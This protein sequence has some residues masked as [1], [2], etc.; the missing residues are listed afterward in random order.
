MRASSGDNDDEWDASY[1]PTYDQPRELTDRDMRWVSNGQ[2]AHQPTVPR[3]ET[4]DSIALSV[5]GEG[6]A[7]LPVTHPS[8][9]PEADSAGATA[10]TPSEDP[11]TLSPTSMK[12]A[13]R[14][15]LAHD[16]D[17]RR[18]SVQS[19]SSGNGVPTVRS[20]RKFENGTKFKESLE[21]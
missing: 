20:M 6:E 13:N 12:S 3:S 7:H 4:S 15:F 19:G 18:F 17:E 5:P 11:F 21:F 1:Q 14:P 2:P 8:P 10:H 9:I 16:G